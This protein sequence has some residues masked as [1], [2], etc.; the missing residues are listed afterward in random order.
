MRWADL[1]AYGHVS[2]VVVLRYL[3]EA[4]VDMLYVHARAHG[5]EGLAQG[6]LVAR[7]EV[8][9]LR[10]LHLEAG[11]VTVQTWVHRL[12]AAAVTLGY[13]VSSAGDERV[14]ARARTTVTPFDPR[15]GRPRRLDTAERRVLGGYVHPDLPLPQARQ[16]EPGPGLP[17]PVR[18]HEIAVRFD[19]LDRYGHVN[20]VIHLEYLQEARIRIAGHG[21]RPGGDAGFV[22]V[23]QQVEYRRPIAARIAPLVVR[24]RVVGLTR[25]SWTLDYTIRD[26]ATLFATGRSTQVGFDLAT[27]R[28]RTLGD[29]ERAALLAAS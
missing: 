22:V 5:A 27:G 6:V 17:G 21:A 18:E 26:S 4:R 2:N 1:D 13:E 10:P 8:E 19:D 23:H 14:A 28:S 20:N 3:Q 12:G 24:A 9:Y 15:T 11:A 16:P 29:T 25:R 7:N